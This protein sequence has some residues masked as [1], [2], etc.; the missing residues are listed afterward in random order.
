ML[1]VELAMQRIEPVA[2]GGEEDFY[3]NWIARPPSDRLSMDL[4][5]D[6]CEWQLRRRLVLC[7]SLNDTGHRHPTQ[8]FY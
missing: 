2:G 8:A 3:R 6:V 4:A 5:L 1:S 7:S